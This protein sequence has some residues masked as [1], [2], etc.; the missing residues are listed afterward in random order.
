[1]SDDEVWRA[2]NS[3]IVLRDQANVLAPRRS[4]ASDGLKGDPA[5]AL[6]DSDH[7]PHFVPGLGANIVTALDLTHDP[8][9]GFDSYKFA[10][11]LRLNRDR[12]IK[13]VISNRRIFSAYVVGST[14]AFV[15]R[16]YTGADPHTGHVHVSTL[17]AVISDTITPWNL[18]GFETVSSDDVIV[19]ESQLWDK[20]A[21][22]SDATGRN[23]ANDVYEVV[24]A[25]LGDE[26]AASGEAMVAGFTQIAGILSQMQT[27][28]D[29]ISAKLD[30]G[31]GNP[32][33]FTLSGTVSGSGTVA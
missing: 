9:D 13:Y 16:K 28:L 7:N 27:K 8:A 5:H 29:E 19:G 23:F 14:P 32:G 2:V 31:A 25:A 26:F 1:M 30:S 10:E 18:E 21:N 12:R 22:R 3:L 6:T 33:V 24:S 11:T 20:A 4:R 15:W 17:D